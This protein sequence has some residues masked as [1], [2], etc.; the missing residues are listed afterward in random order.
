MNEKQLSPATETNETNLAASVT[1]DIPEKLLA[2]R[3]P[4]VFISYS[5]DTRDH[6]AWVGELAQKLM[7]KRID[8]RIDQWDLNPGDDVPKYMEKSVAAADRV[9][10]ICTE[11]YV[12]K[13][14]DGKGGVGYEAMV[15]SGELVANLGTNKF[16][17]I[18]RQTGTTRILP[19]C[20]STRLAI[21]LS[22]L[23][24]WDESFDLLVR[25]IHKVPK[26]K[27]PAL[28]PNPFAK[29]TVIGAG[30][31]ASGTAI[32]VGSGN[33]FPNQTA[34][35]AYKNALNIISADDRVAWRRFLRGSLDQ[36]AQKLQAWR[37]ENRRI[38]DAKEGDLSARISEVQTAV[39]TH[40]ACIAA[41]VAASETGK[42]GFSDQTGWID[43]LL[44][45]AG[46]EKTG[47]IFHITMPQTILFVA[48]TL[49][50]AMLMANGD[51]E[52][53]YSL[54]TIKIPDEFRSSDTVPL[55]AITRC[56][57][58]IESLDHNC[59]WGW[60]F[61][62]STISKW[63]WLK[64]AFGSEDSC[65]VA[66]SAYFQF[67]SFLN[68]VKLVREK[69][70]GAEEIQFPVTV[71]LC[72]CV[73]PRPI[74][75]RGYSAFLGQET[76]IQRILED[77]QIHFRDFADFQKLWEKWMGISYEWLGSVYGGGGP[78]MHTPQRDLPNDLGRDK[79]SL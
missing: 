35:E 28:G 34:D 19:R 76:L 29:G 50:G 38:P 3:I 18:F 4:S 69:K 36:G 66:I 53:A 46:Y 65:K 6:K 41:V 20:V 13:A 72:F 23:D 70:L 77:N 39:E 51:A 44:S 73:W 17:P 10:M 63:D 33:S 56:N 52:A 48:H 16:I 60:S 15:V 62:N 78:A 1:S 25:E 61:L 40:N 55:F 27:K 45:P 37:V 32:V 57:G 9:L 54:G 75:S 68:F 43:L 47:K 5:H 79:Y 59:K 7:Q 14:D 8:V 24:T 21:D 58:W 26:L 71:P 11:P 22:T 42:P 12:R 74:V 49:A 2:E 67:L 30:S 64:T 31:S